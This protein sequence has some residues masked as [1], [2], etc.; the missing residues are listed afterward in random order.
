MSYYNY[1]DLKIYYYTKKRIKCCNTRYIN[2]LFSFP[3]SPYITLS[4][5][6]FLPYSTHQLNKFF[7][8][9]SD[10][11][12]F[13]YASHILNS[14]S[15]DNAANRFVSIASIEAEARGRRIW[16]RE[17]LRIVSPETNPPRRSTELKPACTDHKLKFSV[18]LSNTDIKEDLKKK[19]WE[20]RL[21]VRPKKKLNLNFKAVFLDC[22]EQVKKQGRKFGTV[23][24]LIQ[25]E[26]LDLGYYKMESG[27]EESMHTYPLR[28]LASSLERGLCV[29]SPFSI[30]QREI[31]YLT[32]TIQNGGTE[33]MSLDLMFHLLK[34]TNKGE[35]TNRNKPIIQLHKKRCCSN[36]TVTTVG[37]DLRYDRSSTVT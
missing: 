20:R 29:K 37:N 17:A 5:L 10:F 11:L 34:D 14:S 21:P 26:V 19:G 13:L 7:I 8:L 18:S 4:L 25:F 22:R 32:D 30:T 6:Y 12:F 16:G 27:K 36:A 31:E 24:E 35:F 1:M 28:S 3:H 23:D 2:Q 15:P 33:V 9:H